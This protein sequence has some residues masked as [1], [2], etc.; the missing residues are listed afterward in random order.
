MKMMGRML[1]N[2]CI[3]TILREL[4]RTVHVMKYQKICVRFIQIKVTLL[5]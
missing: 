3:L 5:S 4:P 2:H 1:E